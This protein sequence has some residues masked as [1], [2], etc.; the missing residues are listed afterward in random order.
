MVEAGGPHIERGIRQELLEIT[1]QSLYDDNHTTAADEARDIFDGRARNR[2]QVARVGCADARTSTSSDI[3]IRNIAG[4]LEPPAELANDL[5]IEVWSSDSHFD[6]DTVEIGV[7]P[8]GCGGLKAKETLGSSKVVTPGVNRYAS[9]QIVHPDPII[10]AIRTAENLAATT[11]KPVLATAQGH[12]S[13]RIYPL[14]FFQWD[15]SEEIS[16]SAVHRKY[17]NLENYDPRVIYANGIPK[18]NE[19]RLPDTIQELLEKDRANARALLAKYPD[20]R[21]LNKVQKP[22]MVLLTTDRR[23][24]RIKY[25]VVASVPGSMFKIHLTREKTSGSVDIGRTDVERGLDQ[26]SYVIQ[27]NAVP[28]HGD[29]SKP[30]SSTDILIV[31]TGD[32]ELSRRLARRALREHWM[33]EWK[34]IPGTNIILLQTNDGIVNAYDEIAA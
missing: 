18:L 1:G 20:L 4:A 12:L 3:S 15:E 19:S 29:P 2:T 31:E 10:Q 28:N 27:E 22:R 16:R 32:L 23:L 14:A 9:E 8:K 5:S 21:H 26:L 7:T 11:H 6:D 33:R 34:A 24:A 30:F 25:P 17:L 13:L